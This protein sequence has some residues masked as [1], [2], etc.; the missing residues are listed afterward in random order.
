M[1][2]FERNKKQTNKEDT[3][4]LRERFKNLDDSMDMLL[5][6]H[7]TPESVDDLFNYIPLYAPGLSESEFEYCKDVLEKKA[8]K[9]S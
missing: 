5:K 4:A 6:Q 1:R 7:M 8:R 9:R 3:K 2:F